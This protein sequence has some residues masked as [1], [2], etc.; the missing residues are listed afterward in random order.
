VRDSLRRAAGDTTAGRPANLMAMLR[1]PQRGE[2]GSYNNPIQQALGG[3][4]GGGF[5]F[6][7]AGGL[8]GGAGGFVEPGTYL[9]TIR[10]N[11]REYR[12][13]VT[14]VRPSESSALSGGWR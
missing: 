14:V 5:G 12:Q 8:L 11:G 2:P 9:V 13:S 1:D 4:G 3:G 6:R 10:L 7:G